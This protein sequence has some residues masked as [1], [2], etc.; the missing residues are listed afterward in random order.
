MVSALDT[1]TQDAF[2]NVVAVE[3]ENGL[4]VFV[5]FVDYDELDVVFVKSELATQQ[6]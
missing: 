5:V 2:F 4:V 3:H 1:L 6:L